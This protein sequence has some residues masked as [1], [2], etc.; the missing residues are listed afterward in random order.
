MNKISIAAHTIGEVY[1]DEV[2]RMHKKLIKRRVGRG[3][4]RC[5]TTPSG[6]YHYLE[7]ESASTLIANTSTDIKQLLGN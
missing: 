3:L 1:V 4:T 5:R 2:S 7:N 6:G